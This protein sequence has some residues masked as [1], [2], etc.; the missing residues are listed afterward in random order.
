MKAK[1]IT[2]GAYTCAV[3]ALSL[4]QFHTASA[5]TFKSLVETV[6]S[7]FGTSLVTLIFALAFVYFMWG[8]VQYVLYP[9]GE[10]K[11]KGKQMMVWGVIG[12]AVMFSVYGL[13]RIVANTLLLS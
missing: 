7:T 10:S 13:I 12:L 2:F 1:V 6:I 4:L 5:A 8:V 11:D 9:D 3:L